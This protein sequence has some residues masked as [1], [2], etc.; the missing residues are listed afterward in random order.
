MPGKQVGI[1]AQLCSIGFLP[2]GF[3]LC[4]ASYCFAHVGDDVL[5]DDKSRFRVA[6]EKLFGQLQFLCPK[7][8][9]VGIVSVLLVGSSKADV[10]TGND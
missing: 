9:A 6:A 4:A 1:A 7:G 10:R 5:R 3:L 8:G 2:G